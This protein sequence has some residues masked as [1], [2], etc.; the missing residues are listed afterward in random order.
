MSLLTAATISGVSPGDTAVSTSASAASSSSHSR[1]P[2]TVRCAM[3]AKAARSWL[4]TMRRVI[5]SSSY[6]TSASFRK[7]ASGMSASACR[8]A[9][10]RSAEPAAT[11][12]ST[13][14]ERAGLA[15]A[16]TVFRS[17]K[18]NASPPTVT[19]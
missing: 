1:K 5:S 3:V 17:G 13:S 15:Q 18:L 19:R 4:S 9:T 7:V 16:I 2:P 11:P 14:P 6:G 12:A 10:R 8:A